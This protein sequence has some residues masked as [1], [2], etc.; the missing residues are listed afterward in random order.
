MSGIPVS[1]SGPG[2]DR[3]SSE[4]HPHGNVSCSFCG[5]GQGDVA[6]LVAGPNVYICDECITLCNEIIAEEMAGEEKRLGA[7][8]VHLKALAAIARQFAEAS[9]KAVELPRPVG[10]RARALAEGAR[11]LVEEIEAIASEKS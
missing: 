9:D 5:K 4:D 6:K 1:G 7:H 2:N 10:E 8:E 3:L 11:A